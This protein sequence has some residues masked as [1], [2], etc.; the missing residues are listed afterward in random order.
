MVIIMVINSGNIREDKMKY[1]I[2]RNESPTHRKPRQR[3]IKRI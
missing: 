1:R 3:K 2:H